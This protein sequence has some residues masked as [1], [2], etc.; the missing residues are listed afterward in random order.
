M[1]VGRRSP[2]N[3]I[4][5]ITNPHVLDHLNLISVAWKDHN[6]LLPPC[7][8]SISPASPCC[9]RSF[10]EQMRE[11]R[12]DRTGVPTRR[13]QESVQ[14]RSTLF[15]RFC[16]LVQIHHLGV[17]VGRK[18]WARWGPSIMTDGYTSISELSE[19]VQLWSQHCKR[20]HL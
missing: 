15:R 18:R 5:E 2:V 6:T 20:T 19:S 14:A 12:A 3:L 10:E 9:C 7:G 16:E 11:K 17:A 4:S 8:T 1:E 13:G